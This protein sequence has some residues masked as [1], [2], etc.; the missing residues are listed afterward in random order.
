MGTLAAIRDELA[1]QLNTISG[2]HASA[3]WPDIINLP[4]ALVKVVSQNYDETFGGKTGYSFE[5]IFLAAVMDAGYS[6]GQDAL[7]AYL[8]ATGASSIKA[9]IETDKTLDTEADYAVV[10]GWRDYGG[11]EVN[12]QEFWGCVFDVEVAA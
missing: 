1:E 9:A 3:T 8:E 6:R 10:R 7:D 11:V 2:M 12:G 5:I 4:A